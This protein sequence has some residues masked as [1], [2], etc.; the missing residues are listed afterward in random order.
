MKRIV[1]TVT[2]KVWGGEPLS[3]PE[4]LIFNPSE[5]Q[6]VANGWAIELI[7]DE[8]KTFSLEDVRFQIRTDAE[9]YYESKSVSGFYLNGSLTWI[10]T[11]DRVSFMIHLKSMMDTGLENSPVNILGVKTTV[12]EA[13]N[14]LDKINAY[15]VKCYLVYLEHLKKIENMST[16]YDL[17]TYDFTEKYPQQLEFNL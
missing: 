10:S 17:E 13:I 1:N 14:I 15:A 8:V 3:T 5:E 6:L 11:Q 4:G 2:G 9:N 7:E 16:S 12:V